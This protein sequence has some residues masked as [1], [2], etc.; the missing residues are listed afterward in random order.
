LLDCDLILYALPYFLDD[1]LCLGSVIY[2]EVL[3]NVL[4]ML[5]AHLVQISKL[6]GLGLVALRRL[7]IAVIAVVILLDVG[8]D[9]LVEGCE[10]LFQK[11]F[12]E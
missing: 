10:V 7:V 3:R 4:Q 1:H 2:C 9:N 6:N 11:E 5:G 8:G 12:D